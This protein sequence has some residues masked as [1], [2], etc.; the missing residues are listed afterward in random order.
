MP[1]KNI[2]GEQVA[3]SYDRKFLAIIEGSRADIAA[4]RTL[5]LEE[6]KRVLKTRRRRR[7]TIAKE[8]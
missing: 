2:D 1:L 4:G 6:V 3:L 8:R 5:T 7:A